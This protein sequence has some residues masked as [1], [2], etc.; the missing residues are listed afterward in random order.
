MALDL[1][2]SKFLLRAWHSKRLPYL[3]TFFLVSFSLFHCG[4]WCAFLMK[5]DTSADWEPK[6][7]KMKPQILLF[8]VS[9]LYEL[10]MI[11][12]LADFYSLLFVVDNYYSRDSWLAN[13]KPQ[14]FKNT[15]CRFRSRIRLLAVYIKLYRNA[16]R[17]FSAKFLRTHNWKAFHLSSTLDIPQRSSSY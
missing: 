13:S 11:F 7:L 15:R 14:W 1:F 6:E 10:I 4:L 5:F 17:C 12:I 16:F 2:S 3:H 9:I 8:W